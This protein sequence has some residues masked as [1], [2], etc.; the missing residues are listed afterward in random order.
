MLI[1]QLVSVGEVQRVRGL[2]PGGHGDRASRWLYEHDSAG[3]RLEN[4]LI[5]RLGKSPPSGRYSS[6]SPLLSLC[7]NWLSWV[8][9][10]TAATGSH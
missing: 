8:S 3:T 2:D 6:A 5:T 10:P 9:D 4:R 1:E 7:S